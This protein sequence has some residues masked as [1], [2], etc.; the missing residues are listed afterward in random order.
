MGR[1][2]AAIEKA[3]QIRLSENAVR[4]I[5]EIIDYIALI[6]HQPLN[7][8]KVGDAIYGAIQEIEINPY[9]YKEC[10]FIPTKSRIYRQ[11]TCLSWYIIYKIAPPEIIVLGIIHT[12]RK[13]SKRKLL[14]KV[15]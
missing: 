11:K 3:Y 9:I 14:R 8:I 10:S 12:S 1:K 6:K 15:K 13:P 5:D 4:N 7:A 2:K